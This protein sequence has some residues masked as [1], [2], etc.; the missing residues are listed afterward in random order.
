MES[1]LYEWYKDHYF[2]KKVPI[3]SRMIKA[4]ALE[5]TSLNDF[6]ASKG[7]LEKLKKKYNLQ[8]SRSSAL[9]K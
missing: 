1:R 8:I 4:K 9:K 2:V 3:T 5:L 7:W 6:N